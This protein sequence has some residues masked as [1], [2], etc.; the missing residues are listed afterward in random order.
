MIVSNYDHKRKSG[1]IQMNFTFLIVFKKSKNINF[2]HKKISKI[3][4]YREFN[5]LNLKKIDIKNFFFLIF[6]KNWKKF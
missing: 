6:L 2:F 3:S 1:F 5:Q 4:L